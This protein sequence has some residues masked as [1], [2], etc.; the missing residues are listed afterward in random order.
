[1]RQVEAPQCPRADV[2]TCVLELG[3]HGGVPRAAFGLVTLALLAITAHGRHISAHSLPNE[4]CRDHPLGGTY[5]RLDHTVNGLE[6]RW[7]VHLW[8]QGSFDASCHVTKKGWSPR[9][10]QSSL[11]GRRTYWPAAC[12]QLAE[13]DFGRGCTSDTPANTP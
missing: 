1:M 6:H 4:T 9:P 7:P 2:R 12:N 3:W 8:H 11:S 10:G 13:G 5:A